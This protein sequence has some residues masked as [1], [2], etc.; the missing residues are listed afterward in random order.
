MF[1]LNSPLFHS[2]LKDVLTWNE[3]FVTEISLEIAKENAH[4]VKA[5]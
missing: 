2:S 4:R 1:F 3:C 5:L